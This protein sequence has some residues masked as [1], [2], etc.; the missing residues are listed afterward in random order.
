MP[1]CFSLEASMVAYTLIY[2]DA[3]STELME[4]VIEAANVSEARSFAASRLSELPDVTRIIVMQ[5]SIEV[6]AVWRR[7]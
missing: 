1:P 3:R 4:E 7:Q 2:D 5:R 6:G